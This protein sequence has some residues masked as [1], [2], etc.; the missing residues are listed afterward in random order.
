MKLDLN[1]NVNFVYN[2]EKE[3]T[4]SSLFSQFEYILFYFYPKDN[5]P[6]CSVEAHD[7]SLLKEKLEAN[8]ITV[9]WISKDSVDSHKKFINDICINFPLI[10]DFSL[11]LHQLL[12]A[13]GEKNNYW[14]IVTWVIRSTFLVDKDGTVIQ[15]WKNVKAKWHAEKILKE[16]TKK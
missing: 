3:D 7:F 4:L 10:S 2:W 9:V 5:T 1:K 14:K 13:Y 12:W 11:E 16:L 15:S 6:G 8:G